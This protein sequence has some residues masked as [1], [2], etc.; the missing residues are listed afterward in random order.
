MSRVQIDPAAT[1]GYAATVADAGTR[2]RSA[3]AALAAE[4]A[5]LPPDAVAASGADAVLAAATEAAARYSGEGAQLRDLLTLAAVLARRADYDGGST[6]F[7]DGWLLYASLGIGAQRPDMTPAPTRLACAA[8]DA[9]GWVRFPD[10]TNADAEQGTLSAVGE[11][12]T[13]GAASILSALV[14]RGGPASAVFGSVASVGQLLCADTGY[15]GR[16]GGPRREP[17]ADDEVDESW[18]DPQGNDGREDRHANPAGS[19][20]SQMPDTFMGSSTP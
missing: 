10:Q 2:I 18:S 11:T 14:G 4:V 9:V 7:D 19:T 1:D 16:D 3:I 8:A 13:N 20:G 6:E 15:R 17:S 5:S 12:L